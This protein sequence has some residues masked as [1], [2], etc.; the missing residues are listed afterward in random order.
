M[1]VLKQRCFEGVH[2]NV[3]GHIDVKMRRFAICATATPSH[4]NNLKLYITL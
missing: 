3:K 2:I 4:K 1:L